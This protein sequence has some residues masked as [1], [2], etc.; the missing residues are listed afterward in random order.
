MFGV[1][2]L[3]YILDQRMSKGLGETAKLS[4]RRLGRD[5][6]LVN[7]CRA[8]DLRLKVNGLKGFRAS[9]VYFL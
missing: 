8:Q 9:G 4:A 2:G 7:R 1:V 6:V 5:E 3:G